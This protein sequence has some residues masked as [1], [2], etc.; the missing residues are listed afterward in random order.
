[1]ADGRILFDDNAQELRW[2]LLSSEA[3]DLLL[4]KDA[5]VAFPS[6]PF[7]PKVYAKDPAN[8]A[9]DGDSHFGS[10]D[11][12]TSTDDSDANSWWSNVAAPSVAPTECDSVEQNTEECNTTVCPATEASKLEDWNR[13]LVYLAE[14]DKRSYDSNNV[15]HVPPLNIYKPAVQVSRFQLCRVAF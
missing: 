4:D 10:V 7:V 3:R 14:P 15:W 11:E 12:S 13:R 2:F 9:S 5:V 1:L 8:G 6:L